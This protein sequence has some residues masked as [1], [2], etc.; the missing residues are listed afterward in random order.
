MDL[1]LNSFLNQKKG[2]VSPTPLFHQTVSH[3]PVI[4]CLLGLQARDYQIQNAQSCAVTTACFFSNQQ[5]RVFFLALKASELSVELKEG[6]S[7]AVSL[8]YGS[9]ATQQLTL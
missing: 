1:T 9:A 4:N 6:V 5:F 8:G 2:A 3:L 7:N